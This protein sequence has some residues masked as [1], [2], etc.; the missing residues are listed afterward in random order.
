MYI[1]IFY[2]RF[3]KYLQLLLFASIVFSLFISGEIY[4]FHLLGLFIG[5]I[6]YYFGYYFYLICK[7]NSE[8]VFCRRLF[9]IS[10]I[11][12]VIFIFLIAEILLYARGIPYV[13][14]DDVIYDMQQKSIYSQLTRNG[15]SLGYFMTGSYSGYPNLGALCMYIF[16]NNEWYLPRLVTVFMMSV[17]SVLLY[18]TL[19]QMYPSNSSRSIS[20]LFAF[21][22]LYSFYSIVQLKD[23]VIIFILV[24]FFFALV[25]LYNRTYIFVS[26]LLAIGSLVSLLFFRPAIIFSLLASL[27]IWSLFIRKSN[28]RMSKIGIL[29][30]TLVILCYFFYLW[31]SLSNI[32]FA[33]GLNE[34]M[35]SRMEMVITG[36]K[37]IGESS[38]HITGFWMKLVG[39][40][41]YAT[42]S[43]F[44]PIPTCVLFVDPLYPAL[45]YEYSS[46]VFLYAILPFFLATL[47]YIILHRKEFSIEL[48]FVIFFFIY[49]FGQATTMS[50]FGLRQSLPG[51]LC[52]MY[53]LPI[54]F[55]KK[56]SEK[57]SK[58]IFF[59]LLILVFLWAFIRQ[60][61]RG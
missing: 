59:I 57:H 23:Y 21:T 58:L 11:F 47:W 37:L 12:G 15:I 24:T 28:G 20:I 2:N 46:N 48:Y 54:V 18:L 36:N 22:P 40:P 17:S 8:T 14:L 50:V 60:Q 30:L 42:L 52:I 41:F 26:L 4:G 51:I 32:G 38:R 6:S 55:Q 56:I 16:D 61:L 27:L 43:P 39:I 33:S 31:N 44:L 10:F 9:C 3:K 53:I 25:S 45:N 29:F 35:D 49:K 34:Y 5:F 1:D 13:A 7:N 19:K